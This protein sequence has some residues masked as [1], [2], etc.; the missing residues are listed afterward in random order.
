M[1]KY[2]IWVFVFAGIFLCTLLYNPRGTLAASPRDVVF[3]EIMW[4][5]S[6]ASA[7]DEW[8]V[9]KNNTGAD[10]S[11]DGWQVTKFSGEDANET[12]MISLI[13]EIPAAGYFLVSNYKVENSIMRAKPDLSFQD[14]EKPI[15]LRNE[16]LEIRLYDSASAIGT[17]PM[18]IAGDRK[19]RKPFG[20]SN[21]DKD[22]KI[23]KKSMIRVNTG[24]DGNLKEAW[25]TTE[26][27][28][29]IKYGNNE[30]AT[31]QSS[32][33]N[34]KCHPPSVQLV[35]DWPKALKIGEI[36]AARL[37]VSD[38]GDTDVSGSINGIVETWSV[39]ETISRDISCDSVGELKVAITATD[40]K[41]SV[42]RLDKTLQCY[43]TGA[44]VIN[45]VLPAPKNNDYNQSGTV[46]TKDE[47]IELHNTE[48]RPVDLAGWKLG[49]KNNPQKYEFPV[50]AVIEPNGYLTI[51]NSQSKISLNND[52]D[53]VYFYDPSGLIID[54]VV[55]GKS[56]D[57]AGWARFG[58]DFEWT[59]SPTFNDNNI[60]SPILAKEGV[61]A[62]LNID[63]APDPPRAEEIV[64]YKITKTTTI[65]PPDIELLF[66]PPDLSDFCYKV[67]ELARARMNANRQI[68]LEQLI[69]ALGGLLSLARI[70]YNLVYL[71]I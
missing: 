32:D 2:L 33:P 42:S 22:K 20:G 49:D 15:S 41:L 36:F 30:L 60:S 37:V 12:P 14:F 67:G 53:E 13:G 11:L 62:T 59:L 9:L 26:V 52:G 51:I 29:N 34:T 64:T 50:G 48:T 46:D 1:T 24:I 56:F 25:G 40:N 5:G 38:E 61:V 8:F 28:C 19:I 4:A 71:L 63:N 70:G 3:Y 44:V 6:S 68:L 58:T 27:Q 35:N 43:D 54:K 69:I 31:P 17:V 47:W 39:G 21:G 66:E 65:Q 57:D 45:E 18:D 23:P 55:Y 7:D 16:Y 10:I